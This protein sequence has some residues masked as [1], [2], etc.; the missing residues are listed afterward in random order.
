MNALKGRGRAGALAAVGL[1]MALAVGACDRCE[2]MEQDA[3][4]LKR[5]YEACSAGD[6]CQAVNLYDLA[7]ANNCLGAF[8]CSAALRAGVD[9]DRFRAEALA[10]ADEYRSCG[11]CVAAGCVDPSTLTASCNVTSGLCELSA[12]PTPVASP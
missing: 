9:L 4:A 5:S 10:L 11:T 6:T 1:L 7:G 3:Q 8:Q 12:P 2:D